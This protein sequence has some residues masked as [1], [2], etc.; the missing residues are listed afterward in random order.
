MARL[1]ERLRNLWHLPALVLGL[2]LLTGSVAAFPAQGVEATAVR[3]GRRTAAR[4][5]F[6]AL[7]DAFWRELYKR[8]GARPPH[9]TARE[10]AAALALP[11]VMFS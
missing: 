4:G 6:L 2:I 11:R 7:A 10:Y 9:S 1:A 8:C 5:Q 3:L